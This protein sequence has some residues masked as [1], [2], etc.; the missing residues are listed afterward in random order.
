M[1]R[2][3]LFFLGIIILTTTAVIG[4]MGYKVMYKSNFEGD[5]IAFY[6][7]PETTFDEVV[8]ILKPGLKDAKDFERWAE[9]KGVENELRVGRYVFV[10]GMTNRSMVNRLLAGI[11][12]PTRLQFHH[13]ENFADLAGELSKDLLADSISFYTE[14]TSDERWNELHISPEVRLAYIVPN[15]YEVYWTTSPKEI[16]DRLIQERNSFWNST[17]VEKAE[18]LGMSPEEVATLASIVQKE[19]YMSDELAQVA[20]LYLNRLKKRIKLQADPTVKYAFEKANPD[21]PKVKR[22]LFNMLTLDSPYNTYV[23]EGLPPGPLT[24]AET[25]SIDAVLN[26][27]KH[28]FIFMCADPSRP[29]YHAFARTNSEHLRNA[30]K[31]QQFQWGSK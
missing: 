13:V 14:L 6:V 10:E 27:V 9:L 2:K 23:Y 11:Q 12:S 4:V 29:G 26:P 7:Y 18:H 22:V 25:R 16:V 17:R 5:A 21:L 8:E 3:I 1:K 19:T 15:T 30:R 24:I 28:D 20:G 31:Y